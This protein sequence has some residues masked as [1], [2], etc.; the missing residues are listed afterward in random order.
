M[1][2]DHRTI[3]ELRDALADAQDAI[4][5]FFWLGNNLHNAGTETFRELYVTAMADAKDAYNKA[6]DM[7]GR[8]QR[9]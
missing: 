4:G 3:L 6:V 1:S 8:G 7:L 2:D 9:R 5:G